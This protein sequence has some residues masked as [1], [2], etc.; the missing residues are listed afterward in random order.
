M[1]TDNEIA[2]LDKMKF[3]MDIILKGQYEL[4]CDYIDIADYMTDR[5]FPKSVINST[6]PAYAGIEIRV[7]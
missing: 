6:F 7:V 3:A 2:D 5:K 4:G 1:L